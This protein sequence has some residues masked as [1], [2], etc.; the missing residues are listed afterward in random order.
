MCTHPDSRQNSARSSVSLALLLLV[1][2]GWVRPARAADFA[3]GTLTV[4]RDEATRGCPDEDALGRA[5]LALG[6][7]QEHTGKVEVTV[8]FQRDA[9]GYGAVVRTR[10]PG[11]G[12]RELRKPGPDCAPLAEAVSVVLAIVFDLAPRDAPAEPEPAPEAEPA[13]AQASP[14]RAEAEVRPRPAPPPEHTGP[15]LLLGAGAHG[16]GA[17]GLLGNAPVGAVSGAVRA[18]LARWELGAGALFAPHRRV[19]Y[20]GRAVVLSVLAGRLGACAWLSPSRSRPDIALCAGALLG[21][22]RGEGRGFYRDSTANELWLAAE[23]GA[24]VRVPIVSNVALRLGISAIVPSRRQ[25]FTVLRAGTA[26][27]S[28]PAAGL[29]ELGP[30]LRFP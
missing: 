20:L 1:A 23:A 8:E 28:S 18:Q 30:E 5:T 17:Y 6:T 2:V 25:E 21:R 9:F 11:G 12:E 14:P 7:P 3:G 27:E 26:F 16:G 22:L 29:L 24:A 15:T 19:E 10:G 13:P 4:V